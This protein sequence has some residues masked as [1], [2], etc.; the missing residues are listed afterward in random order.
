LPWRPIQEPSNA[1]KAPFPSRQSFFFI[2]FVIVVLCVRL[3]FYFFFAS[4]LRLFTL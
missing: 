3:P 4:F 1:F 2:L